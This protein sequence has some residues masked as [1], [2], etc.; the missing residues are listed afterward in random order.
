MSSEICFA[1]RR[2]AVQI[3]SAAHIAA[4]AEI[5]I[6]FSTICDLV[7]ASLRGD[8]ARAP[9]AAQSL[10]TG[11]AN[12]ETVDISSGPRK[13]VLKIFSDKD[14]ED[15]SFEAA[16]AIHGFK[17]QHLNVRLTEET[18]DLAAGAQAVS[19]FVN[20]EVNAAVLMRLA[21]VGVK[22]IALRCAGCALV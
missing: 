9:S 12:Q 18:A 17:L 3:W 1:A 16:N 22:C 15:V 8:V 2:D 11:S 4:D 13:A 6:T 21:E 20:D 14:Y 7:Q 19:V 5:R 10:E